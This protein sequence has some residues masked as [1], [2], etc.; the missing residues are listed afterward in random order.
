M[1]ALAIAVLRESQ[2]SLAQ[3]Q[4]VHNTAKGTAAYLRCSFQLLRHPR[5]RCSHTLDELLTQEQGRSSQRA[6]IS[7][8]I[9]STCA[10]IAKIEQILE[11]KGQ[12]L[13]QHSKERTKRVKGRNK[14]A[15]EVTK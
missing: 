2:V 14:Y 9:S 11:K 10:A 4:V 12:E 13:Q 15:R 8:N 1:R 5:H 7:E 6:Q 3:D